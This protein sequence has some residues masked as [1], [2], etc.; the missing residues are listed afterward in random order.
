MKLKF[1]FLPGAL[2]FVSCAGWAAQ[3]SFD[4]GKASSA[5]EKMICSDARLSDSDAALALTYKAAAK[6]SDD[7]AGLKREQIA[8]I[9]TQRD[10]CDTVACM[11]LAYDKRIAV[12]AK[13]GK[14]ENQPAATA[15]AASTAVTPTPTPTPATTVVAAANANLISQV[16]K[17]FDTD[18]GC[19][20][21]TP[22]PASKYCDHG[23]IMMRYTLIV[24]R[25]NNV[26]YAAAVSFDAGPTV[27]IDSTGAPIAPPGQ[28]VYKVLAQKVDAPA[29]PAAS[30][31]LPPPAGDLPR[32]AVLQLSDKERADFLKRY[33]NKSAD[34]VF[35]D[36][37]HISYSSTDDYNR[38]ALLYATY[39]GSADAAAAL[40]DYYALGS[41][42]ARQN[43]YQ[44]GVSAV[45]NELSDPMGGATKYH[46][47]IDLP[48][49]RA[50]YDLAIGRGSANGMYDQANLLIGGAGMQ[51]D[52]PKA[53]SL[54][55]NAGE[56]GN[57]NAIGKLVSIATQYD[58]SASDGDISLAK[59][60]LA[61]LKV[62]PDSIQAINGRWQQY[63]EARH[64]RLCAWADEL[65][66]DRK[67]SL[68][69]RMMSDRN[70]CR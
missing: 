10:A 36:A 13:I 5:A 63:D 37:Y 25:Y 46:D 56:K 40:G 8:W 44:Y 3:A 50:L 30:V 17:A 24:Y 42:R 45:L 27:P 53:I 64:A 68:T 48:T 4:C 32:L 62:S 70:H 28:Q 22:L 58:I 14:S 29:T 67:T 2:F 1:A 15:T 54:F 11:Q 66:A 33:G 47:K 39:L 34:E 26:E 12:L 9:K 59:A 41:L 49:A 31:A 18:K 52:L 6:A 35:K 20:P 65:M 55:E 23:V 19:M 38:P 51:A 61:R 7:P 21:S 16:H 57:L 69:G 60:A 43:Y